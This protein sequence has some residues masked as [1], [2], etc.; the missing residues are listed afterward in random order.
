MR[1][2]YRVEVIKV[3]LKKQK[4]FFFG[5]ALGSRQRF[6]CVEEGEEKQEV[7]VCTVGDKKPAFLSPLHRLQKHLLTAGEHAGSFAGLCHNMR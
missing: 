6:R 1:Y 7:G 5:A 2:I 3:S 4:W